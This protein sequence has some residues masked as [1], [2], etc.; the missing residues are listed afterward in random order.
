[1]LSYCTVLQLHRPQAKKGYKISEVTAAEVTATQNPGIYNNTNEI[2]EK[3]CE[4][5]EQVTLL[6]L[7]KE[8]SLPLFNPKTFKGFFFKLFL[9]N[10]NNHV[11]GNELAQRSCYP[12]FISSSRARYQFTG[13]NVFHFATLCS[14]T[15]C[16]GVCNT[17][18]SW[19]TI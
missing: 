9:F 18:C 11:Y 2:Q 12:L 16:Y 5:K 15:L 1:M 7:I 10:K 14:Y 3:A 17:Y 13:L 6:K 8:S 19:I 4:R